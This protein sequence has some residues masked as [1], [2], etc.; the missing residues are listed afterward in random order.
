MRRLT[1]IQAIREK[2]K[3]CTCHQLR[4]IKECQITDCATWLYRMGRRPKPADLIR[5]TRKGVK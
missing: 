5:L 4:E 3:D 2:C 1:P